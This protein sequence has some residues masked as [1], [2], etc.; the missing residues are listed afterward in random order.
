MRYLGMMTNKERAYVEAQEVAEE[1]QKTVVIEKAKYKAYPK[2][3]RRV[4]YRVWLDRETDKAEVI[5]I[6]EWRNRRDKKKQV[7]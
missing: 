6:Q 2:G 4:C 5:D 1:Q 3:N 7:N